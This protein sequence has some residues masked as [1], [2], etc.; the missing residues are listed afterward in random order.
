MKENKQTANNKNDIGNDNSIS[1]SSSHQHAQ[2]LY[3]FV[4]YKVIFAKKHRFHPSPGAIN[5]Q[6]LHSRISDDKNIPQR[7]STVLVTFDYIFVFFHCWLIVS[8][9]GNLTLSFGFCFF[10]L[11]K[12]PSV[13]LGS[14]SENLPTKLVKIIPPDI[15]EMDSKMSNYHHPL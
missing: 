8:I 3:T 12:L 10:C 14:A 4:Q 5:A 2:H 9:F 6:F 15:S 1:L 13:H 7:P 11:F